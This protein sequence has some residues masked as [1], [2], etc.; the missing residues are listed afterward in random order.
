MFSQLKLYMYGAVGL[1]IAGLYTML[2]Y[3]S[4]KLEA[5]QEK[6]EKAKATIKAKTFEAKMKDSKSEAQHPPDFVNKPGKYSLA[7]LPLLFVFIGCSEKQVQC[8]KLERVDHV[9]P[10][11]FEID[12]NYCV[13]GEDL[14]NLVKGTMQLRKSE[15]F[16]EKEISSYNKEFAGE[17]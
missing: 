9:K 14:G 4:A 17:R 5:V 15:A 7:L 13:C 2:K 6:L 16:Y 12:S 1:V 10:I 8:P 11:N 3:K